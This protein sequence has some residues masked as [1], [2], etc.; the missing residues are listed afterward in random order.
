M[1]YAT[2]ST[3]PAA[4][5]SSI[6]DTSN[7]A[8]VRKITCR[9]YGTLMVLFGLVAAM[10]PAAAVWARNMG[11]S[12]GPFFRDALGVPLESIPAIYGPFGVVSCV[13]VIVLGVL[14]FRQSVTAAIVL[15]GISV[16]TDLLSWFVP[17]LNVDGVAGSDIK[18]SAMFYAVAY[19][20]MLVLTTIIVIADRAAPSEETRG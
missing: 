12:V 16:L 19:A 18:D 9:V 1:S 20:I 11:G 13:L 5:T 14:I 2:E 15:L 7:A 6:A 4:G 10:I 17:A 3:H 8:R